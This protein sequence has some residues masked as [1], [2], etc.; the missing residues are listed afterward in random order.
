MSREVM[1]PSI[2]AQIDPAEF[3]MLGGID[4]DGASP[5]SSRRDGA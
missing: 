2:P 1:T 5:D 3:S 4:L